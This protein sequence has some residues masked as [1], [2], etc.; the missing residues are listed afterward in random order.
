MT[1]VIDRDLCLRPPFLCFAFRGVKYFVPRVLTNQSRNHCVV[2]SFG[3]QAEKNSA[4]NRCSVIT[5]ITN[6]LPQSLHSLS[7][8]LCCLEVVTSSKLP[9]KASWLLR[10][11]LG[12]SSFCYLPV[13][14]ATNCIF[15]KQLRKQ[16]FPS[17]SLLSGMKLSS[18][19]SFP[20]IPPKGKQYFPQQFCVSSWVQQA[21]CM[22]PS[23]LSVQCEI[24]S[25]LLVFIVIMKCVP[26]RSSP[27]SLAAPAASQ[28]SFVSFK[29]F[30]V[31]NQSQV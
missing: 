6:G 26:C 20:L 16:Q 10:P 21:S 29:F 5:H 23:P 25:P 7:T 27:V 24:I 9:E 11:A 18:D 1:I 15:R 14:P 8:P 31:P 2:S 19:I 13:T 28:T 17:P 30:W 4:N 22:H 3:P 12:H